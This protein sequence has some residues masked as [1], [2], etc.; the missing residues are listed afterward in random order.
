MKVVLMK[1][2]DIPKNVNFPELEKSILQFWKEN[3]MFEKSLEKTK[4]K[5]QFVF[6]DGPPFATGLPHYGHILPGTVKDIVPRYQTMKGKYVE[7]VWGWDCHGLPVENLIEKELNLNSKKDIEKYG[8]DK[9]NEACR[10]RVL[11]YVAE[12]EKTIDRMGRWV[13][14][15]NA[16]LTMNARYMESI[17]WVFKT[18]WDKKLIYEGFKILP[19]CYRCATPLSNFET[20]QGYRDVQDPAVTVAFKLKNENNTFILA[21]TTTPWTLPSN[22]ALAVGEDLDY[23]KIDDNGTNYIFAK[24]LIG[25]YYKDISKIRIL[26]EYKGVKLVGLKYEPLFPYFKELENKKAFVVVPGHHVTIESGTG[27]VHIAPGFGEDDA[28][29][30]K[31][32]GLPSVCPVD[33]EGKFTSD[34]GDYKG[35]NVKEADKIIIKRLKDEKKL[36]KHETYQHS[37]PHCWRCDQPLIYKAVTSWFVDTQKIKEGMLKANSK[38]TWVPEHIKDG[39]FGKWLEGARDWAISRNRYWGSPIP[40]WKCKTCGETVCVGSIGELESLSGRK[41][42]DIHKHFIDD[43]EL[44]C[45]CGGTMKR[46]EEVLDCWFESGS[47]PYAQ[48][49]YPFENKQ[50]FEST[51]PADF[52]SESLDQTRGW[53]YTLLVLGVALFDKNAYQNV[54]CNGLVLAE[55]GKKMSKSLKNYPEVDYIFDKYGAD[56]LRLYLMNSSLVKAGELFFSES[57]VSEILRN[58]HLPLWNSYS[59]FITYAMVDGWDP[60]KNLA[61]TFSNPL[62]IWLNSY[63]ESLV[64]DMDKAYGEYDFQKVVRTLYKYIGELTNWYIRR[65]R[66]RFWKSED[67]SDKKEAYTALYNALMKFCMVSAPITPFMSEAIYRNLRTGSM[68]ESVHLCD[69][70]VENGKIRNYELE[71][72]MELVQVTVEMGRSLRSKVSINLRKPLNAVYLITRVREETELLKKMENIVKEEL[73]VK[74]VIYESEEE[75]LVTLSCKANFRVLGKKAGKDM[76]EIAELI[77]RF[78]AGEARLLEDGREIKVN[79]GGKDYSLTKDDVLIERKEKEGLTIMNEGSL[80]VA[81]D[82]RLTDALVEEGIAREFIRQIQNLRKD[83]NLEVTDRIIISYDADEKISKAISNWNKI[84]MEETLSV[85]VK[86]DPGAAVAA[87]VDDTD[88]K[89]D[90]IKK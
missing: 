8:I 62:D 19:Y 29:I 74:N 1:F 72:E 67:D 33:D 5:P 86:K 41:I 21:W 77:Q 7:R 55:D 4:G 16:Y 51:F 63:T 3:M 44:K 81:L 52:I 61:V 71:K 12:W 58:F 28:E 36:I 65:S 48:S 47:M 68:P 87:N 82:T 76:K 18:L 89:I 37:Y 42:T 20:N 50:K 6:Y 10:S 39:R 27:V 84:I 38:I 49:H 90:L 40:V 26:E 59:F 80:T 75:K 66:R 2:N 53:F 23:V 43:I 60:E 83:R 15:K 45:K 73:N 56:A 17:W 79:A 78:G 24:A 46:T 35:I 31:K 9:F 70:P 57:G 22:L 88:I 69:F 13:D 14:F 25:R 85:E 54:V 34:V 64:A 11:R 30:G 32:A